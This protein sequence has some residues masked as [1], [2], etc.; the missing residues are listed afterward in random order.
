MLLLQHIFSFGLL[1]LRSGI[2][3][4]MTDD[5]W[6][7]FILWVL[8]LNGRYFDETPILVCDFKMYDLEI[9]ILKHAI[10]KRYF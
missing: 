1:E 8:S 4:L 3:Q 10:K 7:F 6:S 5:P 2:S 9:M